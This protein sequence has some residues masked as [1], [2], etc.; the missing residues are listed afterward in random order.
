M[1]TLF[2]L[3]S[4][5]DFV[6]ALSGLLNNR[7]QRSIEV[8]A[9]SH[10]RPLYD[11]LCTSGIIN[12]IP[13]LKFEDFGI[14]HQIMGCFTNKYFVELNTLHELRRL[15]KFI[16]QLPHD[17]GRIYFEQSTRIY[18]PKLFAG[19]ANA[20][21]VHD[22]VTNIYRSYAYFTKNDKDLLSPV[23]QSPATGC[24]RILITPGSRKP[25]KAFSK[26][27]A[28]SIVDQCTTNGHD[29]CLAG[30]PGEIAVY[31]NPHKEYRTF[32]ELIALIKNTNLLISADSLPVH[33]AQ[34]MGKPHWIL[35]NKYVNKPWLTPFAEATKQYATF[36]DWEKLKQNID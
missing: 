2:L 17:H 15:R 23:I 1:D 10:L 29:V 33:L 20:G 28:A 16:K 8:I 9:S 13:F 27:L 26:E 30:L 36:A 25:G 31:D 24:L 11:D 32:K 35:Y 19:A 5:G 4:Y 7:L 14:Q 22:G 34:L 21:Y 3:R 6:I 12:E 18:L